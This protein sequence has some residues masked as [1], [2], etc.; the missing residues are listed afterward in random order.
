MESCESRNIEEYVEDGVWL[1]SSVAFGEAV[2]QAAMGG[3]TC[4]FMNA[5]GRSYRICGGMF[6]LSFEK[7]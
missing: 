4:G 2:V 3:T 6:S 7:I 5:S 1:L